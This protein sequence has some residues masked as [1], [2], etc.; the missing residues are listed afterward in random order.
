MTMRKAAKFSD[1]PRTLRE[2]IQYMIHDSDVS[3]EIQAEHLGIKHQTLYNYGNPN[4]EEDGHHYPIKHLLPH[5][6]LTENA[7]VL[8]YLAH[9][10]GYALV[11]VQAKH[12]P[13][14]ALPTIRTPE[15][16]LRQLGKVS[17]EFG[18]ASAAAC[19][20]MEDDK[21]TRAEA[22]RTI[23]EVWDLVEE[24]AVLIHELKSVTENFWP[25]DYVG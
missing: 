16:I 19:R 25:S 24:S 10:L 18:Q 13:G 7:V 21:I 3:V 1:P 14:V 11:P 8:R 2:S 5:M 15:K 12:K 17:R 22:D 23:K 20:A 9:Q 4:L 6:R